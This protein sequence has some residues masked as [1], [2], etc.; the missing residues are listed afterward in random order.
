MKNKVSNGANKIVTWI[1][2]IIIVVLSMALFVMI[3]L[4]VAEFRQAFDRESSTNSFGYYM[5]SEEYFQITPAYHNNTA[6]GYKPD[7]ET[8][9]YYGVAQY[10]EAALIY[11]AYVQAGNEEMAEAFKKKMQEAKPEMGDWDIAIPAIHKQLGIE[12]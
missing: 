4:F 7:A 5:S 12:E 2:N 10:F 9:E 3:F 11:N 6:Y 1:M 8:A